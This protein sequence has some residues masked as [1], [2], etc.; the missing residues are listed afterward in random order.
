MVFRISGVIMEEKKMLKLKKIILLS[1]IAL[2]TIIICGSI[3]YSYYKYFYEPAG[4]KE[5]INK[6]I[7]LF[8]EYEKIASV[9]S[10]I[11][12]SNR[13]SSLVEIKTE[14]A[15]MEVSNVCDNIKDIVLGDMET[16][17]EHYSLFL[18]NVY[19]D[20]P[21]QK[22]I[23]VLK[24]ELSLSRMNE[25]SNYRSCKTYN[26]DMKQKREEQKLKE[27]NNRKKVK[28]IISSYLEILENEEEYTEE[29]F[30]ISPSDKDI[31]T[32]DKNLGMDFLDDLRKLSKDYQAAMAYKTDEIATEID[33]NI[34]SSEKQK[35]INNLIEQTFN[36]MTD[37]K[38]IAKPFSDKIEELKSQ[39]EVKFSRVISNYNDF[40][41]EYIITNNSPYTI[42]SLSFQNKKYELFNYNAEFFFY[43]Q[44]SDK[45]EFVGLPPHASIKVRDELYYF[46]EKDF[47]GDKLREYRTLKKDKNIVI[48]NKKN[49]LDR[50]KTF[51]IYK[52]VQPATISLVKDG[53]TN[54]QAP[55]SKKIEYV[56]NGECLRD[57][58]A[59]YRT[60]SEEYFK[61]RPSDGGL[62]CWFVIN[63]SEKIDLSLYPCDIT[64][65]KCASIA[66]N[67]YSK[68]KDFFG[69]EFMLKYL[70]V[71]EDYLKLKEK[72]KK[73]Y[74]EIFNLDFLALDEDID[75]KLGS[76]IKIYVG[77]K[78]I[79]IETLYNQKCYKQK[80]YDLVNDFVLK[81]KKKI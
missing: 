72:I 38:L 19:D 6:K 69:N 21:L 14:I 10:R 17:I 26:K 46:D 32:N 36:F 45:E 29:I 2:L 66:S 67:D 64:N 48:E 39:V 22:D 77:N 81:Y 76:R 9:T 51:I 57:Y 58:Y 11:V 40:E 63:K 16:V 42:A 80:I 5:F 23:N 27:L 55:L 24:T 70:L 47:A 35:K 41:V 61:E 49:Y 37:G 73:Q 8:S 50:N 52:D 65:D 44:N 7:K 31:L 53:S 60:L 59:Y 15:N 78:D 25:I 43:R 79:D 74:A 3:C 18:A 33:G 4:E 56:E 12:L 54:S 75:V 1:L 34:C 68:Y 20:N 71:N 62:T 30:N 13:I 28:K